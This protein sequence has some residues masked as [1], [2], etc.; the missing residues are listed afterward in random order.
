MFSL[1]KSIAAAVLVLILALPVLADD[2]ALL[3]LDSYKNLEDA[4]NILGQAYGKVGSRFLVAVDDL[5]LE[6]LSRAG[7]SVEIVVESATPEDLQVVL[8]P[9][10]QDLAQAVDI[11]QLGLTVDLGNG[12]SLLRAGRSA[13]AA[14]ASTSGLMIVPMTERKLDLYYSEPLNI[15]ANRLPLSPPSDT[16]VQFVSQDSIYEVNTRLE[17][18]YTRYIYTDSIDRAR[19]WLVQR[20]I[21]WGYTDVTAPSWW[22]N[23]E[24]LFNVKTVKPGIGEPDKVIV[25]GAHY[26][27]V[28]YNQPLPAMVYAPGA[29]DDGSGTAVVMEIARILADVPLRKTVIFIPFTAEEVGLVG[30]THA[31]ESFIAAGTDVEVMYNM[32][33]IGFTG[34]VPWYVDIEAGE[35]TLFQNITFAAGERLTSLMPLI[36]GPSGNSDHAPFRDRGIP[37]AYINEYNFNTLGWHTE[38]DVTSRMDFPYL[39]EAV[40]MI[41]ASVAQVAQSPGTT[42]IEQL[43]DQGD[44]QSIEIVWGFCHPDDSYT[45]Y[46]GPESGVYTD[47]VDISPGNCSYIW[48]GLT[49]GEMNYFK[50][51]AVTYDGYRSLASVE[52]SEMSLVAP[53]APEGIYTTADSALI[54]VLWAPNSE[55]DISFYR[56]YR[57]V[58]GVGSPQLYKDNLTTTSFV[59][60]SVFSGIEYSYSVTTVD[61][62]GYES[63]QSQ[64]VRS[65][66]PF[67][68]DGIGIADA[69]T[70]ENQYHPTQEAQEA[71]LD[72]LFGQQPYGIASIDDEGDSL[73]RAD[74][75][76]FSSVIWLDDDLT[77]KDIIVSEQILEW[78]TGY[79]IN[80]VVAGFNVIQPWASPP[81]GPG[82]ILFDEFMI[83]DYDFWGTP[84]FV[85]AHGQNG[86]PSLQ[87]D[88]TRGLI[89]WPGIPVLTLRPGGTVIYTYDSYVDWPEFEGKPVAVA[90]DGPRGKRVLFSF[91]LYYLTPASAQALFDKIIDYLG[92]IWVPADAG[93]LNGDQQVDIA[94]LTMLIDYL[95]ITFTPLADPAAADA[96]NDCTI[97]IADLTAMIAYLFIQGPELERGC[98][99]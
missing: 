19:D 97:D 62:D 26:D 46:K 86:W 10:S 28:T 18:F 3:K 92:E 66:A 11:S 71:W 96:N 68:D 13:A 31:A 14:L 90:Y 32:D 2:I 1:S 69:F 43:V 41:L 93:D 78:Y 5:A 60:S 16:L 67:F 64:I 20:F 49:A 55:A 99:P 22:W 38:L 76:R 91:P 44:G 72:S 56:L 37:I 70:T 27:A 81:I 79:G 30:S 48:N 57:G 82:H 98:A 80:M 24:Q 21:D 34:G 74:I 42:V 17:A 75:G 85:G 50:V 58:N 54:E 23:G 7:M 65:Y 12:T 87:M 88:P 9:T 53:R 61:F 36:A 8:T 73:T 45:I 25:I 89:E 94:D 6:Q 84:D 77:Q 15:V 63:G 51:V 39:T 52:S 33:M 4:R 59:D 40:K 95:F 47:S 83:T 29:D 35:N